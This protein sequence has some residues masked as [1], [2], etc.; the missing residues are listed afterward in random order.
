M[1]AFEINTKL[2]AIEAELGGIRQKARDGRSEDGLRTVK[3]Y[4]AEE[5]TRRGQLLAAKEALKRK[6]T[7]VG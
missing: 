1:S 7:E 3:L 4:T 6:L 2:A 5:E